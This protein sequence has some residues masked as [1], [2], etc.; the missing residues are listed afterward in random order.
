LTLMSAKTLK[1]QGDL[2]KGEKVSFISAVETK[3]E[4]TFDHLVIENQAEMNTKAA[5]LSQFIQDIDWEESYEY[6]PMRMILAHEAVEKSPSWISKSAQLEMARRLSLALAAFTFTIMG[7]AFGMQISRNR[8]KKG[9][10][11]AISLSSLFLVCFIAAK[12]L[13]HSP[14]L[15]TTAYLLPHPIIIFLSLRFLKT[16]REG[17]E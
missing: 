15:S 6:M 1:L 12:S 5:N 10:L 16:V 4:G 8:S 9:L 14:I 3:K 7:T 2:L 17:V 13:R 11:W